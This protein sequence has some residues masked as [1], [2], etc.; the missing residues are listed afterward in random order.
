MWVHQIVSL[1]FLF[2][3]RIPNIGIVHRSFLNSETIFFKEES[4]EVLPVNSARRGGGGD[5][6]SQ[7]SESDHY[8]W[9]L[10]LLS[11][12]DLT[13]LS[14]LH[15]SLCPHLPL[16]TGSDGGLRL[17]SP[18]SFLSPM[19]LVPSSS[20]PP[21]WSGGFE[22]LAPTGHPWLPQRNSAPLTQLPHTHTHTE[23]ILSQDLVLCT[24]PDYLKSKVFFF[25]WS[26]WHNNQVTCEQEH[27][28]RMANAEP[29][30][31]L[32]FLRINI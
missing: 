21:W 22:S 20:E 18:A 26:A 6:Q 28:I 7:E 16:V 3:W 12:L 11:C 25:F 19:R 10:T 4:S 23:E 9:T 13:L 14:C 30:E 32:P 2:V 29:K 17:M 8:V 24:Q 15:P 27:K 5:G 31:K 1:I